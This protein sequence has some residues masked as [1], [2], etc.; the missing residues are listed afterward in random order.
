MPSREALWKVHWPDAG[1]SLN[2]LQSSRTPAHIRLIFEELF[3]IEL[4]LELKRREQKAQ[5]GIAFQLNDQVREAIKKIL[6]FHPTGAQKRA[7]KEIAADMEKPSPMRRLAAGRCG[8]GQD[9]GGLRSRN[10]RH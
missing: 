6:P 7:L 8:I 4:G 1:E 3:F 9:D 2:D 5:T 10:H